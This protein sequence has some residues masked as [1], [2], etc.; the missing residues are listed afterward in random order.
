M[1]LM[2][3]FGASESNTMENRQ[4][5]FNQKLV[6]SIEDILS[7]SQVILN[8]LELNTPFKRNEISENPDIFTSELEDLFGSSAPG[9]EDLIIE[10][11]YQKINFRY[12]KIR[13]KKFSDYIE[14]AYEFYGDL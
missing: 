2:L 10:K 11:L 7:F 12:E 3:Q 6:E 13:E 1:S 9:I 5:E 8:F 4:S 14:E